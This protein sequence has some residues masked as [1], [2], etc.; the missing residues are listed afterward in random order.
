MV[1][2]DN[3]FDAL[4]ASH[5][6]QLLVKLLS[7][8]QYVSKPSGISREIAE[9]DENLLQRHLSSSRTIAEVDEYSVSMHHIHL[10]KLAKYGFIVWSQD[11]DLVVRGH[12]FDEIIPHLKLLAEQQDGRRTKD[13]V[14]TKGP[15]VTKRR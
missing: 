5:R 12:R 1:N 7:I 14:V 13:P 15:V 10:P 2:Y 11:D 4:T 8:P 6:R 9:A 3:V